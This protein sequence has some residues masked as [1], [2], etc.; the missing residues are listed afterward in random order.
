[1]DVSVATAEET[2]GLRRVPMS[3]EEWLALPEKP[4]VEWVDGEAVFHRSGSP[5]HQDAAANLL[6][7]LRQSLTGVKVYP[8]VA[9][10][11]P[12]NRV[13]IPDLLVT[14]RRPEGHHVIE[15][16]LLMVE[17]LSP[18]TRTEDLFRK[19]LEYAAG[20]VGQYWIVDRR[21]HSIDVLGNEDGEWS[22]VLLHLDE[23][24]PSGEVAVGEHGVVPLDLAAVL[25]G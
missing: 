23:E 10:R 12:R 18:S 4:K 13:R 19:S 16:P 24:T 20:G 14:E 6:I 22:V 9:V 11:L 2:D 17:V 5:D 3:Y 15:P 25:G 21:L 8:E 7:L 1:M